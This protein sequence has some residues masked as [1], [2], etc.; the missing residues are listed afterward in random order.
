MMKLIRNVLVVLFCAALVGASGLFFY[1]RTTEDSTPPEFHIDTDPIEVSVT[2]P[3]SALL[4]GLTATD[5][6]DG[7][8]TQEIR[9]RSRSSFIRDAE[10]TVSYIVFDQASN[11]SS[12][13]RH[14]RYTDYVPP[15]FRL[16]RP[17]TFNV[18]ETIRF[19][20]SVIV[21]DL[22]EGDI[23]GRIKLEKSTVV[24]SIPGTYQ[25]VLSAANQMGDTVT[26][27]L[28][29]QIVDNS[30][31]RATIALREYLVYESAEQEPNYA[32]FLSKV[33]D[34]MEKDQDAAIS[35]SSVTI[36]DSNVRLST[37]GTYEVYYYYTGVSG[38]IATAILTVVVE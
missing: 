11:Y 23:S 22:L 15:R 24:N 19:D 33:T 5:N 31:T 8:L 9:I 37:P 13:S 1:V 20:G 34:P 36:N 29:I 30:R 7:D 14:A 16:T 26:L 12:C 28:S 25:V 6:R 32:Q 4:Q 2:D 17:M 21:E 10:F 18:N 35:L 3:A 27:P 38:E